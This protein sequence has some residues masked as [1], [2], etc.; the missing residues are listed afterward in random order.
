MGKS[1]KDMSRQDQAAYFKSKDYCGEQL[2]VVM[3]AVS[4]GINTDYLHLFEDTTIPVETMEIMFTSM[5]EDYGVKEAAFLSTVHKEESGRIL[6]EALKAGVPLSELQGI[7]QNGMLPIELREQ[8]LPLMQG[9]RAIP[10]KIGEQMEF[11]TETVRELKESL[12]RQNS[13]IEDLKKSMEEKVEIFSEQEKETGAST[14]SIDDAYYL[15]LEE[16][17]RQAREDAERL[18]EER[19]ETNRKIRE[20]EAENKHLHEQLLIQQSYVAGLQEQQRHKLQEGNQPEKA[21]CQRYS[22]IAESNKQSKSA[23]SFSFPFIR[24]KPGLLEKLAGELDARQIAEVRLGIEDG[25]TESQL[26]LLADKAMDA[27]K[28]RELRMTMKILNERGQGT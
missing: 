22:G 21:D 8:I 19:E 23:P 11:L 25:L 13:F 3:D 1:L 18:L 12:S 9:R 20:L 26:A 16:Q 6:L 28:M 5:K 17:F 15:E 10:E 27:E 4:Y 2:K 14:E 7:Y 24:K